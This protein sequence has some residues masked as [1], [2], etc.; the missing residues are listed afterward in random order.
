MVLTDAMATAACQ[1]NSMPV[2]TI[3]TSHMKR[4]ACEDGFESVGEQMAAEGLPAQNQPQ[5]QER[6]AQRMRQQSKRPS[7]HFRLCSRE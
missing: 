6:Q 7:Q 2:S 1:S 3:K 5:Q 4:E